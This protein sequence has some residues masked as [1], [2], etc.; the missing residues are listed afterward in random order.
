MT[1]LLFPSIENI[2]V[3]SVEAAAEE[4][5]TEVRST[6]SG[7]S[8]P[9]CGSWSSR[10][11]GSYVRFP[12]DAPTAGRPVLLRLRVRRFAC[13]T[14]TC[15]RRTFVEQLTGLR[16]RHGRRTERLRSIVT[17]VGLALAGRAGSRLACVFGIEVSRSTVL[18]LVCAL[19]EP[20][21][22]APRVVGIDEYATRKGRAYGTVVID[23][24][25]RRPVDLLPDRETPTVAAWL[26]RRPG[27]RSSAAIGR[28]SSPK[29]PPSAPPTRCR[30]PTAGTFGATSA[31]PPNGPS[32]P[33]AAVCGFWWDNQQVQERTAHGR[34][35]IEF[36]LADRAPLREPYRPSVLDPFKPHLDDRW[37]EGCTNAWR[38]WE[39][40]VPLG[41]PG[42]YQ[43][44]RAY[45]HRK[46]TSPVPVTARPPT[47]RI[48]AGWILR[49]PESRSPKTSTSTS[50]RSAPTALNATP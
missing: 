9:T 23:L 4:I 8:C 18:R 34:T 3:T 40:I 36:S 49:H 39:E 1:D 42:S 16:W 24:E 43:R 19:P 28:R 26:R 33:T 11:H 29:P 41:Y 21:A 10:V 48:V 45:L 25:T 32:P 44:V 35:C 14:A 31:K 13:L 20:Q 5:R 47:P 50:S 6:A 22:P 17:A 38:L 15:V 2:A 37:N 27:S 7:A 30:S 46:R 12:A